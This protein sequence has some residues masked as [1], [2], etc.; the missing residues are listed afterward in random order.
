MPYASFLGVSRA[1][2]HF[3][4]VMSSGIRR[5]ELTDGTRSSSV[6]KKVREGAQLLMVKHL[7]IACG[8]IPEKTDLLSANF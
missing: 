6:S 2:T 7:V 1:D 5:D 4:K 8:R 3:D